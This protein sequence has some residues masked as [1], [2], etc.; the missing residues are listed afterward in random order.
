VPVPVTALYAA[1]LAL[2]LVALGINVA[3]HRGKFGIPLS[4]GGNPQL[5]RMIRIHGNAAEYM[6]F[7][8]LL[9]GL[10]EL[11]GGAALALHMSGIAL[12][13]GRLLFSWG[14]WGRAEPGFGRIAGMSLT[15][16]A[17]AALALLNLWQVS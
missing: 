3:V 15:W 10:Y 7:A 17:V 16:L 8:V 4:D 1:I 2:M 6:P 5:L 11:D 12:L 13:A 14:I 9:M